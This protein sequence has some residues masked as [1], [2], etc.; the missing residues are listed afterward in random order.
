VASTEPLLPADVHIG[1]VVLQVADLER[2]LAFYRDVIGFDLQTT[3]DHDNARAAILGVRGRPEH[4]LELREKTGVRPVPR[5]GLLGL[6]HV[7]VLLPGRAD[8]GRFIVHAANTGA[9]FAA[10]DHLFSEAL[11][12]TDPDGLQVEVYCDRP[13]SAWQYRNGELVGDTLPLD[14][15]PLVSAAE[16]TSCDGLPPGTTIGHVHF[17]VGD[18]TAARTFYVDGLGFA[19]TITSFPGALFVSAGGY[20][21]HVGLNTWASGAPIA[22]DGDARLVEWELVVDD[23]ATLDAVVERLRSAGIV[24]ADDAGAVTAH[25]PWRIAVRV[26]TDERSARSGDA[27]C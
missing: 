27:R 20:H 26:T 21:H 6:Y 24:V 11:Y 5:R 12:L 17:Y 22:T 25:D 2:S 7:A 8:L 23:R 1:R 3:S 4:L 10:A 16:G 19:P 15:S 9:R 14:F 18:L 13:K